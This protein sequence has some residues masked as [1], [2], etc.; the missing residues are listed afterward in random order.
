MSD[1]LNEPH[2]S[3]VMPPPEMDAEV[4]PEPTA[5][6][7][8]PASSLP[9]FGHGT[10]LTQGSARVP[11][12]TVPAKAARVGGPSFGRSYGMHGPMRGLPPAGLGV[13]GLLT[14][15]FGA[16]A[17]LAVLVGPTFGW[18]P[19][20]SSSLHWSLVRAVLHVAP[21]GA[22]VVAGLVMI[23]TVPKAT[24]G[25]GR[26]G[27][28]LAGLLA[29][30]AGA[31]LAIGPSA[32]TAFRSTGEIVFAPA[33]PMRSFTY[34]VG[35]NLGPGLLLAVTGAFALAWAARVAKVRGSG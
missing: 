8:P 1:A 7:M 35:A 34:V 17:A 5:G 28:A 20:G 27:A 4:E 19:E 3:G 24:R 26:S 31:W 22:A 9:D 6:T 30:L 15:L 21:G 14:V 16:W 18:D 10:D 33:T 32:W 13:I 29:I 23:A 2:A 25:A 12:P 11:P